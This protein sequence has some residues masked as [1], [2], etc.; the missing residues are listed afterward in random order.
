M[1]TFNTTS[2]SSNEHRGP[3]LLLVPTELLHEI[4]TY[5]TPTEAAK[6]RRLNRRIADVGVEYIV[7]TVS[8]ALTED[9]FDRLEAIA[10]HPRIR[11]HVDSMVFDATCLPDLNREAWKESIQ[12]EEDGT[13]RFDSNL[14]LEPETPQA[15]G[16]TRNSTPLPQHT[17]VSIFVLYEQY[18]QQ[19]YQ[20]V[21]AD[22]H[23]QRI[24]QALEKLPSLKNI[25]LNIDRR[26]T[27]VGP[28]NRKLWT[29]LRRIA[30]AT[31]TRGYPAGQGEVHAIL[32][33]ADGAG[34]RLE[35]LTCSLLSWS[36]FS[37]SP[38]VYESYNES[39]IHLK[40]LNLVMSVME[41]IDG[42]FD[43]LPK[44]KVLK[45][46]TAAPYLEHMGLGVSRGFDIW[47]LI[48]LPHLEHFVGN[49]H[50]TLLAQVTI[51][52]IQTSENV[53]KGFLERHSSTLRSI[54][55]RTLWLVDGKWMSIIRM[56][57]SVLRLDS[58]AFYGCF[59]EEDYYFAFEGV[60]NQAASSSFSKNVHDYILRATDNTQPLEAYLNEYTHRF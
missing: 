42:S 1:K 40:S 57:R 27:D 34:L 19:Q 48:C 30:K 16:Q 43:C 23:L 36:H 59:R 44:G 33:S 21:Q 41:D 24:T 35:S 10:Q 50:W 45:S 6:F 60:G 26:C 55:L 18:R 32:Y 12:N 46:L 11:T 29:A 53:F 13:R 7:P 8:L 20:L 38:Q 3:P 4:F 5:L 37:E 54:E 22:T 25:V 51:E 49:F 56:M 52:N 14:A 2:L 15:T 28:S 17:K 31:R 9:S 39:L 58:V 47:H